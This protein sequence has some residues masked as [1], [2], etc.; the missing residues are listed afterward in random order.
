MKHIKP[1]I[2]ALILGAGMAFSCQNNDNSES[3][4]VTKS[5]DKI[6]QKADSILA[7]MT[8]DEKIGQLNQYSVG[9]EMTGPGNKGATSQKRYKMLLNGEVGSVLNLLGAENTYKLQKQVVEQSRLGIPLIFAYDVV[10]GYKTMFPLPLAESCSWNLDLM[11]QSAA[12][13]AKEAASAGL[14]WTFAP[15]VDVSVDARWGRVM[16]GA[17]EDPYLGSLIA[18]ARVKGFQG[19]D[20]SSNNT[21]AACA[22]HFAGYGFVESGKD[23]NNVNINKHEL[24]NRILPP[25]KDAAQSDVATFMNAFNDMLG[26]PSTGNSYLL[27]EKLRQDWG[28]EGVVVSDWNS[29]G[30]MVNHGTVEDLE[31]AAKEAIIAGS[32][33]DMEADAYSKYLKELVENKTVDISLINEAVRRVLV[34]KYKLGLFEDPYKYADSAREKKE[35]LSQE[36]LAVSREMASE[37]IVLLK[38]ETSLLPLNKKKRVAVIGPLAKDK[39]APLG[40][41]RAAAQSNTA[42]SFYEGLKSALGQEAMISYAKGCDLSIGPNNFF[43]E[44]EINETDKSGFSEAMAKASNAEVVFMVL[45]EPA[46]MSGEGRSRSN[47]GLPG[48]QLDLLKEVYKV[49]KNIVL[50]LMNGRPLTLEWEH[51]NIPTILETWHLGSE[52]GNAIADVIT[53]QVNPSGKLTMSFPRNVG[54]VPIYYNHKTSGRPSTAPGQVFYTHHTDVD[55]SPLFPF[56]FGLSYSEFEYG[57]LKLSKKALEAE[58]DSIVV[59]IAVSNKSKV[60]GNEIVQLYIQDEVGSITRP[61]KELKGFEKVA[62]A[63]G[64]TKQVSFTIK[65]ENLAYYRR[66]FTYGTE[67]GSFKVQMDA[68]SA[69]SNFKIFTLK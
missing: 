12:V 66:D 42:V 50:V 23:Y 22:K 7:L 65:P 35:L 30:E 51:E 11:Q 33:I 63:A 25:F 16:E 14:Q 27:R 45:G 58:N 48:V 2:F 39:D 13:A 38:N 36:N 29:I 52:A 69:V 61:V 8:L 67:P 4:E 54:Q 43:D 56:G 59:S 47:I 18:Q 20:L 37:S 19:N 32:D 3:K 6:L 26:I 49:N 64:E 57:E 31:G 1:I 17:G 53:G 5:D 44:L 9:A 10:H 62:I 46:Y 15:M 24:L 55:N 40:N 41:W 21:I 68:S 34:L 28:Y 60:D